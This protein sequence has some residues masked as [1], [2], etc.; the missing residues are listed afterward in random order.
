[1]NKSMLIKYSLF[2]ILF[3][4]C[5]PIFSWLFDILYVQKIQLNIDSIIKIHQITLL[6]Y[7]IDTAPFFLGVSFGFA[8]YKHDIILNERNYLHILIKEKTQD[9]ASK[10]KKLLNN[11][12]ELIKQE[13]KLKEIAFLNSHSV[14]KHLSSILGL[15]NLLEDYDNNELES[16][17]IIKSLKETSEELDKSIIEISKEIAKK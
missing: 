5:F 13:K 1:M 6:H 2:G 10:N 12:D 9:L 4:C 3:G 7:V 11:I 17:Y 14:R 15:V 16:A 8:G